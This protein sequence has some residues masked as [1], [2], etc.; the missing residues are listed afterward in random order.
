[1]GRNNIIVIEGAKGGKKDG[2]MERESQK[3]DREKVKGWFSVRGK[4][5]GER[6]VMEMK[7]REEMGK[8]EGKDGEWK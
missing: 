7:R 8:R 2:W 1:M 5:K 4:Y 6:G 3:R